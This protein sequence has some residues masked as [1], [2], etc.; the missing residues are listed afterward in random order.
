VGL[1]GFAI[2]GVSSIPWQHQQLGTLI[3]YYFFRNVDIFTPNQKNYPKK[4]LIKKN[5]KYFLRI[6]IFWDI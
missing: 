1:A 4:N 2:T 3:L 5:K 6:F